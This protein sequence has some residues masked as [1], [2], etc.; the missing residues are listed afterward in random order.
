[1]P[2]YLIKQNTGKSAKEFFRHPYGFS[3]SHPKT[4]EFVREATR[5][6]VGV[7]SY[8]VYDAVGRRR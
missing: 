6:K 3:G 4:A 8:K 2:E 1:M 5:V 7:L